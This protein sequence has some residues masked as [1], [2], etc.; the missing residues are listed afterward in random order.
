MDKMEKDKFFCI[1]CCK[2]LK[3]KY[4]LMKIGRLTVVREAFVTAKQLSVAGEESLYHT[5]CLTVL[6]VQKATENVNA[7]TLTL[8]D[9]ASSAHAFFSSS[10]EVSGL[11]NPLQPLCVR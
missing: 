4:R 7:R 1:C 11:S 9:K 3:C 10:K 5:C 2:L 6:N 8:R